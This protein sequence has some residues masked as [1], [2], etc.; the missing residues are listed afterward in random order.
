MAGRKT[1]I[2]RIRDIFVL[3]LLITM[4]FPPLPSIIIFLVYVWLTD[5]VF[6]KMLQPCCRRRQ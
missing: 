1:P 6:N 5:E 2:F 4:Q 3:A